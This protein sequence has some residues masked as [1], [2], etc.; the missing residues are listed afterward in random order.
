MA[1][2]RMNKAMKQVVLSKGSE[3][4]IF[5]YEHGSEEELLDVFIAKV[6]DESVNF[7]WFDAAVLS[8]KLTQSL[9]GSADE[10]L[11]TSDDFRVCAER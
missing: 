4:F 3:R 10:L 5:R 11:N 6:K 2:L 7:D 9:I 1:G 8:F